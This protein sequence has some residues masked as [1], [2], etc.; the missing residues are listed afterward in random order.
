MSAACKS[1]ALVDID[2]ALVLGD[3][4]GIR[5]RH[6]ELICVDELAA[7]RLLGHAQRGLER[8]GVANAVAAA[9]SLEL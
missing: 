5:R 6:L 4:K 8:V 3:V 9:K 7:E 1:G 2:E